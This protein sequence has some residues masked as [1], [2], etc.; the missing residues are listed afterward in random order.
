MTDAIHDQNRVKVW[1]AASYLD[2]TTPV[3]LRINPANGG[4]KMDS[5]LS[6]GFTPTPIDPRDENHTPFVLAKGTDGN[7]YPL[8]ADPVTGAL[9]I[10]P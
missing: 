4:V 6:I 5:S 7:T 8:Y 1:L 9:L 2:G 10:E 3:P